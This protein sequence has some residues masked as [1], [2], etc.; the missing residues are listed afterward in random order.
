MDQGVAAIIGVLIGSFSPLLLEWLKARTE[1]GSER[2]GL[3]REAL[4]QAL[5]WPETLLEAYHHLE[6]VYLLFDTMSEDDMAECVE[7]SLKVWAGQLGSPLSTMKPELRAFLPDDIRKTIRQMENDGREL[8][9]LMRHAAA[10]KSSLY[11]DTERGEKCSALLNKIFESI[12]TL[13]R[14]A[15]S[16]YRKKYQ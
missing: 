15:E 5:G 16:K 9:R 2:R 11:L 7:H 12:G 3:E 14:T 8:S 10:D 1:R 6:S 13:E 4:R